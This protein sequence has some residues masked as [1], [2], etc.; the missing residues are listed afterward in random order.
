VEEE[1]QGRSYLT[2]KDQERLEDMADEQDLISDKGKQ[3]AHSL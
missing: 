2:Q 1:Q 3:E